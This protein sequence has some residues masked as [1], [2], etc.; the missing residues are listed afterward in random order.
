MGPNPAMLGGAGLG[1]MGA[2][3]GMG[4]VL[5]GLGGAA[6][7]AALGA[8]GDDVA[9]LQHLLEAA[10]RQQT[11]EGGNKS[12]AGGIAGGEP[13]AKRFCAGMGGSQAQA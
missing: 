11:E 10:Q 3:G 2:L 6:G 7:K 5:G 4:G 8:G 13:A 12:G 9:G 1:A